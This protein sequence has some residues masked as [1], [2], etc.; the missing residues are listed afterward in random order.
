MSYIDD[1]AR[2]ISSEIDP[3]LL[4]DEGDLHKLMRLYALLVLVAG[5]NVTRR[6]VHNAWAV[7]M[8]EVEPDHESLDEFEDLPSDVRE[9]DEPFVK[10]I[11]TV[12]SRR[13]GQR[14]P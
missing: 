6:D 3:A 7:W 1:I 5:Q 2:E 10:A 4:P 8:S 13:Q 14:K 11:R 12:A 9:E